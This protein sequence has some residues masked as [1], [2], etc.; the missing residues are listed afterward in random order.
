MNNTPN[1]NRKHIVFYGK[2]N[3]GKSSIL[4]AIVGQKISLVSNIKG[5]TTDPVSKAMELIPFGPVLF[6]DTAGIDD[7]SEL[8]N[9]RVERTL[10]TLK[11][12]DFAV[13]VMDIN[14]IDE[15]EYKDFQ[16]KFKKHRIP[17]TTVIN[18][19][20]TV[21]ISYINSL[22]SKFKECLFVSS[23]DSESILYLKEE[24]I[25]RLQE[26]EEDETI[27]GDI[28]PYNGKVIMV[29][30]VDSE[31]PKGRL[32]LPQ[33]QVIRDCLDH[34]IKSYVVRDTE[35]QSALEDIKDVDLVITDSQEFKKVN[36]IV[37]K[38][39][40]L[41]SFS[42]LF[43]RHKGDL[44]AF[45][46]GVNKIEELNGNSKILISESCT[47]NHSHEDIGRVKIPNLLNKH[48][49]KKLNYEFKMGHDFPEN[50]EEYDLIIHCGACMVNKKTMETRIQIC[51]E[52][53]VRITNYGIILAYLTGILER[54]IDIF[55][56]K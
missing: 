8:G 44:K 27:V 36:K 45:R 20:D 23:R 52:K 48:L 51:R 26:D 34:G 10:K 40:K 2:T 30:P 9:L 14:N 17:Y 28:V 15:N 50:I 1:S 42:I 11:K 37:P 16:K 38:H 29:V 22:K 32:I 24:L 3:S 54:S 21:N 4:N 46:D 13:Y 35:L 33:V 25:K 18:K 49:G 56:L 5:T 12:T 19:I 53:N 55:K 47:H 43:A 41:T 6:I 31:A 39:I 7:K